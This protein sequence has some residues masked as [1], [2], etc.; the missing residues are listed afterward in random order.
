MT[1]QSTHA[2]FDNLKMGGGGGGG[3]STPKQ[4][5]YYR[6]LQSSQLNRIKSLSAQLSYHIYQLCGLPCTSGLCELRQHNGGKK[7]IL[8]Q[9]LPVLLVFLVLLALLPRTE[10]LNMSDMVT[11]HYT[12]ASSITFSESDLPV[13]QAL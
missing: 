9:F 5:S 7:N 3:E 2:L 10:P 4:C 8:L 13:P 6:T 12:T 1:K 11:D